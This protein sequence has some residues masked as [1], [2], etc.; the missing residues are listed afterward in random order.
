MAKKK[1]VL[2]Y[3]GG[4]DTSVIM[5]WLQEKYD[6][7]VIAMIA[8]LGQKEDLKFA[9]EKAYKTG[10]SKVYV[11]DLKKEFIENYIYPTLKA[12][13]VYEGKY[14]LGTSFGRPLIAKRQVEIAHKEGATAVAH[15]A[16]GKGND[17]VR[18]ELTYL[19]LDPTLEIIAPWKDPNW[20][21]TSREKMIEYAE[22]HGIPVPVTKKKIY[23]EDANLWHISHEGGPLEDPMN[24]PNDDVFTYSNTLK[25][26]PDQEEYIEIGFE[27][28]IP[29]SLNGQKLDSVTLLEKL[30]EIGAKHAIGQIDMVENRLVGMKSRGVYETPGGTILYRALQELEELVLDKDTYHFKDI[31]SNKYA[32]LVYNGMWFTPLR[33]ALDKFF[34]S[35]HSNTTGTVRLKLYKGNVIVA[36]KKSPFSLYYEQLASFGESELYDHKDA[37]GFIRLLGLPLIV[38]ALQN[39]PLDE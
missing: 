21:L 13:A 20:D 25:N 11:E 9:E 16:T 37:K 27:K 26:A 32:E 19:A 3:S 10:A 35:I 2:A 30:N 34:N 39:I 29:V 17:Q 1:V 33:I 23:S 38:R 8:D 15:G 24:E 12:R 31:L 28:G 14:L 36:G 22:K 18:F 6:F 4:L 7:E 5:K